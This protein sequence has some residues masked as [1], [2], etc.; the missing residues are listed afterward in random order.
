MKGIILSSIALILAGTPARAGVLY[1]YETSVLNLLYLDASPVTDVD[2]DYFTISFVAP[3]ALAPDSYY[4][5]SVHNSSVSISNWSATDS[6]FGIYLAG[7]NAPI[8]LVRSPGLM[9]GGALSYCRLTPGPC[10]G[11]P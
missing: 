7:V 11:E 9:A 10:F 1:T 2:P 3:F 8:S 5:I 6:L 4:N